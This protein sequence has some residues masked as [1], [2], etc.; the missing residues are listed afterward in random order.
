M[1]LNLYASTWN[2]LCAYGDNAD[3]AEA[4]GGICELGLGVELWLNWRSDP[5]AVAPTQWPEIA[6]MLG[7]ADVTLH[8]ALKSWDS[9]AFRKEVDMA[10]YLGAPVLVVH[11]GSLG[12]ATNADDTPD[13][14][15]CVLASEYASDEGVVLALENL[16]EPGSVELLGKA[17]A[18]AP[19]LR[20][21]IDMAHTRVAQ[22]D[23]A[24]TLRLFGR[25][26]VHIHVSDTMGKTDE[27]LVP[28]Q[29]AIP[30]E[31]WESAFAQLAAIEYPGAVVM[32]LR[33]DDPR[34]AAM[35]G[36]AFLKKVAR[37]ASDKY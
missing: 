37:A 5:T 7:S 4:I 11:A 33:C 23:I 21:C 28:G 17:L 3:L 12:L 13:M 22:Y 26:V 2:Y 9:E 14:E 35:N 34:Q 10:A 31:V 27:H 36:A 16:P 32:E 29:G 15:R 30:A 18:A 19:R 8:S 6:K 20:A 1:T 25:K 24:E